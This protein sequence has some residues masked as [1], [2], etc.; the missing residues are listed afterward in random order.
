MHSTSF[1]H[2]RRFVL[3]AEQGSGRLQSRAPAK[4]GP[5]AQTAAVEQI[6]DSTFG[7]ALACSAV[8]DSTARSS[9]NLN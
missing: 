4:L 5:G 1:Q 2:A 7:S 3:P 8:S 6:Y 9:I